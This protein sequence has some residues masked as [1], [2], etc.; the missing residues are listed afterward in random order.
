[1]R[2]AIRVANGGH[3]GLGKPWDVTQIQDYLIR[4]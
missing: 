1:M 3:N 4:N 2:L